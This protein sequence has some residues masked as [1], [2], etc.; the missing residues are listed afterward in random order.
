MR[1]SWESSWQATNVAPTTE[2]GSYVYTGGNTSKREENIFMTYLEVTRIT[3]GNYLDMD[4]KGKGGINEDSQISGLCN[5][6]DGIQGQ[7]KLNSEQ[8]GV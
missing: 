3:L 5:C 7:D 2:D 1:I 8:G 6:V 4:N